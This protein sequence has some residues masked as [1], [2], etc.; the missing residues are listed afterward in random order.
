MVSAAGMHKFTPE[1]ME[2]RVIAGRFFTEGPHDYRG[3]TFQY[4]ASA[5]TV[6][7]GDFHQG[8][9]PRHDDGDGDSQE[10]AVIGQAQSMIAG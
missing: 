10:F 2:R 8:S 3:I 7:G 5:E 4:D 1:R 6:A 9:K